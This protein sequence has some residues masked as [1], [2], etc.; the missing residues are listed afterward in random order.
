[1][2]LLLIPVLLAGTALASGCAP[3]TGAEA[4][5]AAPAPATK[6]Q[7]GSFGFDVVGVADAVDRL[8]LVE[9]Q[10][11]FFESYQFCIIS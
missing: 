5:S 11:K 1:M 10:A 9:R 3:S 4:P 8:K 7:L 6:P 2:R